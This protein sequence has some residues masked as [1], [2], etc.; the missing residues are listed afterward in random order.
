MT[1]GPEGRRCCIGRLDAAFVE[2]VEAFSDR[3]LDVAEELQRQRRFARIIDQ[4]VGSGTSVGANVCEADEALSRKDFAKSIGIAIKEL[5]ETRYWFRRIARREWIAVR[6]LTA[7]QKEAAELK[8]IL[9]AI[10]TRTRRN[11]SA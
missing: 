5:N 7:L 3:A 9:G 10:L 8:L 4:L 2:R 6:R 1:K 11:D